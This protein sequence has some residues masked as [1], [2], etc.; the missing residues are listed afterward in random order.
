MHLWMQLSHR[1]ADSYFFPLPSLSW[2][3]NREHLFSQ[4]YSFILFFC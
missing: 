2:H 3:T 1:E 4:N